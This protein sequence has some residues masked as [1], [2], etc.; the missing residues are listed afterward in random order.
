[1]LAVPGALS[2]LERPLL[3]Y[4]GTPMTR[5][6]LFV[7][8]YLARRARVRLV[9]VGIEEDGVDAADALSAARMWLER[10]GVRAAYVQENRPPAEAILRTAEAHER[11][12]ILMGGLWAPPLG[13]SHARQHGRPGAAG[14][15]ASGPHVPVGTRLDR[16]SPCGYGRA[17]VSSPETAPI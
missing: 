8:A 5:E 6:A 14:K 9:V 11:D 2:S 13:G 17:Q 4:D 1:V 3:A 15:P 10:H 16:S 7:A 12:L